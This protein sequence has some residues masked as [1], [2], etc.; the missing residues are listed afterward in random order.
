MSLRIRPYGKRILIKPLEEELPL[1][2]VRPD[3]HKKKAGKGTVLSLGSEVE[4][5]KEGHTVYFSEYNADE[6]EYKG[7]TYY[8]VEEVDVLMYEDQV[9]GSGHEGAA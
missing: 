7:T 1:G 4:F 2:L 9:R 3:T 8:L 5:V 6:V